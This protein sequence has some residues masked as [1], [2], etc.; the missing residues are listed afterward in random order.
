PCDVFGRLRRAAAREDGERTEEAPL[1]FWEEVVRPLDRG[2]QR[3]LARVGVA[4]S[5]EEVEALGEPLEDLGRG[6]RPRARCGELDRE[7]ER[8]EAGAELRDV[9]GG[10]EPGALAEERDRLGL[11]KR[12]DGILD[13]ALHAQELA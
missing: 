6:E 13:L 4:S 10:L 2:A 7:R 8:V 1:L 12:R 5:L 9:L 3:L 11:G